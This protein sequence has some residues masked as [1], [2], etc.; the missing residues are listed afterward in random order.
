[1]S[2]FYHLVLGLALVLAACGG[3]PSPTS[4]AGAPT[5]NAA[6]VSPTAATGAAAAAAAQ[7]TATGTPGATGAPTGAPTGAVP[8]TAPRAGTPPRTPAAT[9]A[10]PPIS[11]K[12]G[13]WKPGERA[14]YTITTKATGQ[15]A[16]QATYTFGREFEADS[17]SAKIAIGGTTDNFLLG[18]NTKTLRPVSETRT[19][20]SGATEISIRSEFHPGGATVEVTDASGT[21]RVALNLPDDYFANDQFLML[22][23]ALPFAAGYRGVINLVPTRGSPPIVRAAVVVA[24]QETI[25]TGLGSL[26]AWRVEANFGGV[27]EVMWYGVDAPHVLLR[28][29]NDKYTY[30]LSGSTTP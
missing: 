13:P 10:G 16:G 27:T 15:Q 2:R 17:I 6:G 7:P 30:V 23:R 19:I 24:G 3:S 8:A 25:A 11:F 9:P 18:F 12:P 14:T 20:A 26:R 1:M 21:N 4:P 29:D 5:P 28:Y 22:L